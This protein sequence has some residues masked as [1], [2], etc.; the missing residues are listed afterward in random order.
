VTTERCPK[1]W[2]TAESQSLVEEFFI[3]R[4]L[5]GWD[6]GKLSARQV[7]AFALLEAESA[8]ERMDGQ[9]HGR[10]AA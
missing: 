9:H 5:G 8:R 4:R 1:G 3:R 6:P 2:I 7:E 10:H